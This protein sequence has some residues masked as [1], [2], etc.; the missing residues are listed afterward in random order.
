MKEIKLG[1]HTIKM[2][3]S[4]EELPIYRF[5]RFNKMI[6]L[7]SGIGSDMS[8]VDKHL[9]RLMQLVGDDVSKA[10]TEI[11]NLRQNIFMILENCN[12]GHLAFASLVT[13]I[14]GTKYDDLSDDG[15]QRVVDMLGDITHSEVAA[16]MRAAKKKIDE[17]MM[18]YFPQM[19]DDP[20]E[21]ERA[22]K[23]RRKAMLQLSEIINGT[24]HSK[25]IEALD[26][27]L[28]ATPIRFAGNE[29]AEV[30]FDKEFEK[31]CVM[32]TQN[33]GVEAK[34]YTVTEFYTAI[35]MINE[36]NKKQ[37]K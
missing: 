18:L 37:K 30:K 34:K 3:D 27:E 15:L 16:T 22:D 8:D 21:K 1:K 31:L 9:A 7:D 28:L 12:P 25:Q 5:H 33:M 23:I 6:L 19:Y 36:Q 13:E 20:R 32:I 26:K 24:D 2:Y 17:E 4:V 35:E 29:S 14:D 10:M 11:E